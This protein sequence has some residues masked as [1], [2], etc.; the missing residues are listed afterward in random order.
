MI[1]MAKAGGGNHYYGQTAEDL[2]EPFREELELMNS[3]CAR[4][5]R[6]LLETTPGIELTVLNDYT[7]TNG[8]WE[9]PD[10]LLGGEAWALVRLRVPATMAREGSGSLPVI[11]ASVHYMDLAGESRAIQDSALLVAALPAASHAALAENELVVRRAVELEA[12]RLQREA[13]AAVQRGDWLRAEGLLACLEQLGQDHEWIRGAVLELRALAA[14]RD[15]AMFAR[16][17]LY[18]ASRM[19]H[20][21][22][23]CSENASLVTDA[24]A[25]LFLRRKR[26][27]GKQDTAGPDRG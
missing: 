19:A 12:A 18:S 6:L 20:R 22:A 21:V 26:A 14:R 1:A 17:S 7:C 9:L 3:I 4:S 5:L 10:L 15:Q 25:P 8:A 2:M 13:R 16:E 11:K 24:D 27:Q 23:A